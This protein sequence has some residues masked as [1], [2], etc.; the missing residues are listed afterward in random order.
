MWIPKKNR[1]SLLYSLAIN[2]QALVAKCIKCK[3]ISEL[4]VQIESQSI[5]VIAFMCK[6]NTHYQCHTYVYKWNWA[7]V[8]KIKFRRKKSRKQKQTKKMQCYQTLTR[9]RFNLTFRFF[10]FS[11]TLTP[12][13]DI[14][15]ITLRFFRFCT[16]HSY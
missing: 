3:W 16:L 5:C 12:S 15:S 4:K 6:K 2:T 9:I 10:F 11:E 13:T 8:L 14:W 1:K 7:L